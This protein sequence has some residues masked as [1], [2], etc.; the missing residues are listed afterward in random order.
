MRV[1]SATPAYCTV[2][3]VP[4][5]SGYKF[6]D[7]LHA[8]FANNKKLYHPSRLLDIQIVPLYC[9]RYATWSP[10]AIELQVSRPASCEVPENM[11]LLCRRYISSTCWP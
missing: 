3:F 11:A 10:S 4:Q 9:I 5:C 7:L 2:S 8:R 1:T 6:L